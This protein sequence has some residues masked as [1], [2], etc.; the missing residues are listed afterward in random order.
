MA[1]HRMFGASSMGVRKLCPG[2]WRVQQAAAETGRVLPDD[3]DAA[4]EGTLLHRRTIPGEP[5]DDLEPEQREVVEACRTFEATVTAG[6]LAVYHEV[7]LPIIDPVTG[8]EVED[9]GGTADRVAVFRDSVLVI[10]WK[11]GRLPLARPIVE[12][13]MENYACGA[14]KLFDRPQARVRVFAPRQGEELQGEYFDAGAIAARVIEVIAAG[15]KPESP[16]VAGYLQCR[17]CPAKLACPEF[18]ASILKPGTELAAS[19]RE[20]GGI[21]PADLDRLVPLA[22]LLAPMAEA[23]LDIARDRLADGTWTTKAWK[24]RKVAKRFVKSAAGAQAQM[25]LAGFTIDEFAE[26]SK[27]SITKLEALVAQKMKLGKKAAAAKLDEILGAAFIGKREE[28]QLVA[29]DE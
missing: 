11:F 17:Y 3:S 5:L 22:K 13:Q 18:D 8:A 15:K 16:L 12:P 10:D 7:W 9:A 27:P 19:L 29:G 28:T 26:T 6:A 2:S 25:V 20:G 23:V 21:L 1:K 24:L 4:D 14:M